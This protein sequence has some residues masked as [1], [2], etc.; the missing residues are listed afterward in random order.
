MNEL[1]SA[2]NDTLDGCVVGRALSDLGRRMYFPKGVVAQ[3]A[4]A[5]EHAH[6]F[7]AT[8]GIA[9][10]DGEPMYLP[11]VG[12]LVGNLSPEEAFAYAPTG[13]IRPLREVWRDAM[14]SKNPSLNGQFSLPLATS[15][16]THAILLVSD[17]FVGEGDVVLVPDLFW[18]NYRLIFAERSRAVLRTFP[19]FPVD[20]QQPSGM[21]LAAL[22]AA[23]EAVAPGS[24]AAVMLN[25]P[26]NPTGYSPRSDEADQLVACLRRHAERGVT[27]VAICDDAYTGLFY[28]PDV[29]SESVFAPL[30][31][32]HDNLLAVKIDGATKENYAW[33]FRVGFI[34]FAGAGVSAAQLEA[35][36]KKVMGAVRS[37]VSNSS[38]LAQSVMLKAMQ[39]AHFER[40]RTA[41][42]AAMAER[43]AAVREVVTGRDEGGLRPLPFNSGYFM[44]LRLERGGSEALRTSLLHQRGIGTISV[45][46]DYL[47]VAYS[48]IKPADIPALFDEIYSAAAELKAS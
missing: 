36:E 27:V 10:T 39:S 47:R 25:F 28:E 38:R 17:L 11:S 7:D 14:L 43:Y 3:T 32:A 35:L 33:G 48:A 13:G 15:G 46:D 21:D 41:N 22:D 24:K 40:E 29:F 45:G 44:T 19:L 18:G 26:N 16:L 12:A 2:L 8:V 42:F 34:S 5:A 20:Q 37:S 1:A 9:A 6:R 23:L 31:A 30:A 4:E